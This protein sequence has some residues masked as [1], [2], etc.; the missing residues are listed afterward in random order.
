M[1]RTICKI[2]IAIIAVLPFA[3][4]ATLSQGEFSYEIAGQTVTVT[5]WSGEGSEAIIP[6]MIENLPVTAIAPGAFAYNTGITSVVIP[7]GVTDIGA[8]AF[9]ECTALTEI[10]FMGD[11]PQT[12][13]EDALYNCSEELLI[14]YN[15]EASGWESQWQGRETK[16]KKQETQGEPTPE[17]T[18]TPDQEED[19]EPDLTGTPQPVLP[20]I[21]SVS[22]TGNT[23]AYIGYPLKLN[24]SY[25][26][27]NAKDALFTW[28]SSNT[29]IASVSADGLVTP[30]AAGKVTIKI[31]SQNGNAS[32]LLLNVLKPVRVSRVK[33]NL[34]S[35][36]I[37]IG[38]GEQLGKKLSLTAAIT[39]FGA[40]NKK[41]TWTSSNTKVAT[42]DANGVVTSIG[43]GKAKITARAQDGSK[44]YSY[45][46]VTVAYRKVSKISLNVRSVKYTIPPGGGYGQVFQITP[47]LTPAAP[48]NSTLAFSSSNTLVASV[49]QTGLVT[50]NGP[51]TAKI[52]VRAQDGSKKYAYCT[53]KVIFNKVSR[54]TLNTRSAQIKGGA[55]LQLTARISP[56][57]ASNG[58]LL[59][60]SS[61]SEIASVDQ[62]GKVIGLKPG[63]VTITAK[64][65]DNSGKKATCT[66]TVTSVAPVKITVP[67]FDRTKIALSGNV[68][69]RYGRQSEV[70]ENAIAAFVDTLDSHNKG[71]RLALAA[72]MFVG[73]PYGTGGGQL[74]CSLLTQTVYSSEGITLR[75]TSDGQCSQTVDKHIDISQLRTGDLA[76]FSKYPEDKCSCGSTCRRY[77]M[78]HHVAL[79][80][81]NINGK[82]YFIEASSMI[83]KVVIREWNYT[84]KHADMDVDSF[85]HYGW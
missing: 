24:A 64:A 40:T 11:A 49:T 17:P 76:F 69:L 5:G 44:K 42:V 20:E 33:L 73:T 53:V 10:Y 43:A 48:H 65:M 25:L 75:R 6:E 9:M 68:Y 67:K 46:T 36:S 14:V 66:V 59:W 1:R 51:G 23:T 28:S 82:H 38:H 71:D 22:I 79:Y 34:R 85:A 8:G 83:G 26:P 55:S 80:L 72:L 70:E 19:G 3:G 12:V 7:A 4:L 58:H 47:K 35:A 21:S 77:R 13:G 50:V 18:P 84:M 56:V 29:N 81:G 2:L 74:D 31:V 54:I 62:N 30:K 61:N 52:Y 37:I 15:D 57:Y 78:V 16:P 27:V 32:A 39:P 45:C 41:L 60:A 63:K